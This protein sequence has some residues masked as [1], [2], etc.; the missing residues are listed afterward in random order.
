[1]LADGRASKSIRRR[2]SDVRDA[3]RRLSAV[4]LHESVTFAFRALHY[5]R[6]GPDAE[7]P[8]LSPLYVGDPYFVR[9]YDVNTFSASEC[10]RLFTGVG[11]CPLF[12]RLLGSRIVV[13]NAELR[14]PLIGVRQFGLI[15]FPYLPTEIAPFMDGGLAWSS[16]QK[17]ELTFN[18]NDPRQIPIFSA[19][20]SARVN[21]LGYIVAEFYFARPFQR[22]GVGN[23]FG[24]QILPGW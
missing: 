7:D 16:G 22:P 2:Q 8:R 14:I 15:N 4:S 18:P 12:S 21:V 19:G 24:F 10:F 11:S 13:A 1:M 9:G 23:Q 3:E 17:I 5:G 6:Y 20:I